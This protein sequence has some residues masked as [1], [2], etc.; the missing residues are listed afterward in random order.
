MNVEERPGI[1]AG[2]RLLPPRTGVVKR[3]D[4]TVGGPSRGDTAAVP[5]L[6]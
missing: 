6:C 1:D 5:R 3:R 2:R 4:A